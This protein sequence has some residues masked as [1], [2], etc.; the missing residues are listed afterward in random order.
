MRH[1]L[2]H[3]L[4]FYPLAAALALLFIA[5]SL[6]PQSWP[7]SARAVTGVV[8]EGALVLEGEALGTPEGAPGQRIFVDRD[9]FGRAQALR[10]AGEPPSATGAEQR[11]VRILFRPEFSQLLP[12]GPVTVEIAYNPLPVNPVNAIAVSLQ[13][14]GPVAWTS[15]TVS[16]LPGIVRVSLPNAHRAT[17]L[18]LLAVTGAA[19]QAYGLE[20]T[21]IRILPQAPATPGN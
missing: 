9:F 1:W 20:I 2:L 6:Q 16:P 21:R 7:R 11:G 17:A 12:A 8:S 19:D 15:A 5:I 10:I 14:A 3:P 18:G 4:I 13:D